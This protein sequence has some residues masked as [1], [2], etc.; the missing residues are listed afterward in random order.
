MTRNRTLALIA[1]GAL[2]ILVIFGRG[3]ISR[4]LSSLPFTGVPGSTGEVIFPTANSSLVKGQ[5]YTLRWSGGGDEKT[6]AIFVIDKSLESQGV[7]VSAGDRVYDVPNTGTYSYTVLPTLKEGEY[8]LQIGTLTSPYFRIVDTPPDAEICQSTDLAAKAEF[9]GAAGTV[10]GTFTITNTST[11][12]CT[13]VGENSV[14]LN[15]DSNINNIKVNFAKPTA[16]ERYQLSPGASVTTQLQIPNGPQCSSDVQPVTVS[17]RY[18]MENNQ[19]LTFV[20]A[21]GQKSF[22]INSCVSS[23]DITNIEAGSFATK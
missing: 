21:Q 3:F 16:T 5:T 22:M 18:F 12:D 1:V 8:K 19:Q 23:N 20:D 7:S 4:L 6:I 2:V 14:Q 15:Y 11:E 9:E 13:L 17:Y 10:Y